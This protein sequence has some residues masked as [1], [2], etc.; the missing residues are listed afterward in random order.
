[1]NISIISLTWMLET[2]RHRELEKRTGSLD[3]I[4]NVSRNAPSACV[5]GRS[6]LDHAALS[7][8]LQSGQMRFLFPV[9]P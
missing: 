3:Y 9:L 7:L 2:R 5:Y 4:R 8:Q 6:Q 1:M